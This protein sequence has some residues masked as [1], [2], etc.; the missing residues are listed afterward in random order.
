[1]LQRNAVRLV[2]APIPV[3]STIDKLITFIEPEKAALYF[4]ATDGSSSKIDR[5]ELDRFGNIRNWPKGFFGDEMGDLLAMTE[6]AM[7]AQGAGK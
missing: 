3:K 7:K 6:A 2:K 4:C 5:L 1:M